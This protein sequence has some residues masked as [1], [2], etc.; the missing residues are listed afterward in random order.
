MNKWS[1]NYCLLANVTKTDTHSPR[2]ILKKSRMMLHRPSISQKLNLCWCLL[3]GT[4]S[5]KFLSFFWKREKKKSKGLSIH[6]PQHLKKERKRNPYPPEREKGK[7]ETEAHMVSITTGGVSVPSQTKSIHLSFSTSD[8]WRILYNHIIDEMNKQY[9][10]I[11][12]L[13][14]YFIAK[15]IKLPCKPH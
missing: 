13:L 10:A 14:N 2:D 1:W 11:R 9:V 5:K 6:P 3:E 8:R 7:E 12:W 4:L 15:E